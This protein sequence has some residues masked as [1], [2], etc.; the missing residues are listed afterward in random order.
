MK[1]EFIF[2]EKWKIQINTCSLDDIRYYRQLVLPEKDFKVL[3]SYSYMCNK[4]WGFYYLDDS[5]Y[6]LITREQFE[7]YVINK[8]VDNSE[9]ETIYKKLL[10]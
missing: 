8:S 1:E 10:T 2:P 3:E 6:T 7:Q 4:G 5:S 9:L